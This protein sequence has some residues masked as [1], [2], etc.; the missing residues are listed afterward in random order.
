MDGTRHDVQL[1]PSGLENLHR[2]RL[3]EA[4]DLETPLRYE[5]S[6]QFLWMKMLGHLL[7]VRIDAIHDEHNESFAEF[8][9]RIF[10]TAE[11]NEA[12]ALV[13]DL[14]NNLGGQGHLTMPLLHRLIASKSYNRP[15]ALYVLIGR[16]TFSA[17]MALAA[18]LELHAHA[19]FVG[20]PT[21]SR[22]NFVGEST[23]IRL[24]Y[25]AL[26]ISISSRYHQNGYS[27]DRR[28]WIAPVIPA[29]PDF[30]LVRRGVD[31]CLEAVMRECR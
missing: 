13:I 27:F 7:Y 9:E 11:E 24:P 12:Q 17:A 22:P 10:T 26:R 23:I 14:R 4:L 20:E 21:G 1:V 18:Q 29:K 5:E 6:D 28:F 31:P 19:R 15:G 8:T 25:S 3:D 2:L 30:S 16:K